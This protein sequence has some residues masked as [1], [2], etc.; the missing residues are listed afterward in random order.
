MPI[1]KD[2]PPPNRRHASYRILP[3]HPNTHT[4]AISQEPLRQTRR[5]PNTA[6]PPRHINSILIHH[7]GPPR[8]TSRTHAPPTHNA[9][10]NA[11]HHR[12]RAAAGP[13]LHPQRLPPFELALEL[14]GPVL[15]LAQ[16]ALRPARR[17]LV[18]RLRGLQLVDRPEQLV[19]LVAHPAYVV[20]QLRVLLVAPFNLRL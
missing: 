7:R 11:P 12:P 5:P 9:P 14:K 6:L 20:L 15:L 17:Q 1:Q 18:G 16:L 2:S 19:R 10:G 3:G 8:R 13:L 4:A